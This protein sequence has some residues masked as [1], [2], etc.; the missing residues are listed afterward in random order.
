MVHIVW[1][2]VRQPRRP[3]A[4]LQL[5]KETSF[6]DMMDG[7]HSF[8]SFLRVR[9]PQVEDEELLE[10]K[11]CTDGTFKKSFM[12]I[13]L[14]SQLNSAGWAMA[15][16]KTPSCSFFQFIVQPP[17]YLVS[18]EGHSPETLTHKGVDC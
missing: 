15:L 1:Q 14:D 10:V 12:S 4:R 17:C 8:E 6:E 5:A 3:G 16:L 7:I 11:V 2:V 13:S 9:A 18:E